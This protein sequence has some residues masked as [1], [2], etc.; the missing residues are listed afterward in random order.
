MNGSTREG[1]I[2]GIQGECQKLRSKRLL[3]YS[4]AAGVSSIGITGQ[5][6]AAIRF[7]NEF[8]FGNEVEQGN[9]TLLDISN[10]GFYDVTFTNYAF[11]GGNYQG[12]TIR[13]PP[14]KF[15]GT[16]SGGLFY[17]SLLEAGDVIDS[18]TVAGGNF[19]ASLSYGVN[20]PN[21]EFDS[22]T[23]GYIGLS[24]PI[25]IGSEYFAWIRVDI[26]NEA[27]TFFIKDWAY[28]DVAGVG[29]IAGEIPEPGTLGLLAAG[30]A[31]LAMHR[32]RRQETQDNET[33]A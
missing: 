16:F 30:A 8:D 33:A 23:D 13:Y 31:G 17:A 15:V 11:F 18:T 3:G 6:D 9:A 5:A 24:F 14:G 7:F 27:G 1:E 25:E 12:G 21:G 20:N 28:E 22:V 2:K 4:M 26:D 29:I 10:N 32:R 19:A